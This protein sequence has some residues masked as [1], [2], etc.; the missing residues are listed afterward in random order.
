MSEFLVEVVGHV[1]ERDRLEIGKRGQL[2][3]K[4]RPRLRVQGRRERDEDRSPG[5]AHQ[6]RDLLRLEHRVYGKRRPGRF[7]S[8]NREVGLGK[9]RQDKRRRTI[10]RNAERSK[11]VCRAR[12]V[13]DEFG[14]GPD[15]RL[16]EALGREE[17]RQR[18]PVGSALRACDERG[19]GALGQAPLNQR[20][21]FDRRNV[22]QVLDRHSGI[23]PPLPAG[24][25]AF[26]AKDARA[27]RR[28]S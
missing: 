28:C 19:I 17:E 20:D 10:G 6:V 8:P 18:R 24:V 16:V 5:G 2:S 13:G 22:G 14:V 26:I 9:V 12:H 25:C 4:R 1:D 23:L 11:E 21:G 27:S 7:A 3:G 15:M